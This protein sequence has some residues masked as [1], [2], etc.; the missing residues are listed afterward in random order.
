VEAEWGISLKR[1]SASGAMLGG[2]TMFLSNREVRPTGYEVC[3]FLEAPDLV[4]V[5]SSPA[6]NGSDDDEHADDGEP[7]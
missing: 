1:S 4:P 2:V 6:E 7:A 3:E 5:I